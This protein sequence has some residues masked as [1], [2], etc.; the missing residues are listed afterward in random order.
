MKDFAAILDE[1]LPVVGGALLDATKKELSDLT[2]EAADPT[3]KLVFTLMAE[4]V[5]QLGPDGLEIA[6]GEIKRL[7]A[8]KKADIDWASPKSASDAVAL[9]QNAE[10][11]RKVKVKEAVEKAGKV[12]GSIGALFFQAAIKGALKQ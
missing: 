6:E 5:T 8:G 7:L 2:A 11:D 1:V 12:F 9:L 3:K 4:A 10:R